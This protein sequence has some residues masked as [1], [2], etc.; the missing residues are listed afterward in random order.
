MPIDRD[1]L[2]PSAVQRIDADASILMK[3]GIGLMG[4]GGPVAIA[5]ALHCFDRARAL[6]SRLPVETIPLLRYGLAA[7]WLNRA[8]ALVRLEDPTQ[9]AAAL[10]ALD[11]GIL[12][13]RELPLGDDPRFPRRLSI[14]HQNRGLA[15]HAQGPSGAAEAIVAF[16]EAIA[17]LEHESAVDVAD[18]QHAL[19]TIWLNLAVV[20]ASAGTDESESMARQ[21]ARRAVALVADSETDN[22]DAA[23]VGLRARHVLC[24]TL[25]ARL[26]R[27]IAGGQTPPE[28]VH[29]ATDAADEALELVRWWERKGVARFRDL[30]YDLFRFGARVYA[31][32]QPQFLEDFIRDNMDPERSSPD[33][34]GSAEMRAAALDVAGLTDT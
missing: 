30:A 14:A 11:Q 22:A 34:V 33:Y 28:D 15:L 27:T 13:L 18:R 9:I 29:D 8:E 12:L 4:E 17:V 21:A 24:Q 6:R 1:T 32:Y 7:C 20:A 25:A 19:S 16:T 10:H 31:R 5:E 3:R 23:E 2:D 26:S